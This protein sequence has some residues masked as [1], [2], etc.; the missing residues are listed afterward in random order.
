MAG[1]G[2]FDLF[3][4]AKTVYPHQMQETHQLK[5]QAPPP[6]L[7]AEF[8]RLSRDLAGWKKATLASVANVSLSTVERVER[9][10]AVS[11]QSLEKIAIALRQKPGAFTAPRM[12]LSDAEAAAAIA[13]RLAWLGEMALVAV[14][15]LRKQVQLRLLSDAVVGLV[16]HDLGADAH[17]DIAN[18]REWLGLVGFV[19]AEHESLIGGAGRRE[20]NLRRLY[21]DV[22]AFVR[23]LERR[24]RCV[25][26]VGAYKPETR[27]R[28]FK[29]ISVGVIAVKS[30]AQDPVAA[31]RRT[32][33]APAKINLAGA[34]ARA[35]DREEDT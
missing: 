34:L 12:K 19:R 11:E 29:D 18:L 8:V 30:K 33:F 2:R 3:C 27:V 16:D 24:R 10:D 9:G 7:I 6:N 15:P 21:A 23:D 1:E 14:A 31:N 25:C 17:D 26:L 13:E 20:A 22:L 4:A 28:D 5:P 32:L 35:F